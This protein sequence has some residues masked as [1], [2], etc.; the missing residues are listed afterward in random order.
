VNIAFVVALVCFLIAAL[1]PL[2]DWALGDFNALAWGL[3][4]LTV[5]FLWPAGMRRT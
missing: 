3:A 4:A 5:G 2:F 1:A